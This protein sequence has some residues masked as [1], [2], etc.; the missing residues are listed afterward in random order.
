MFLIF[1]EKPSFLGEFGVFKHINNLS[2]LN[3]GTPRHPRP[4]MQNTQP[5]TR[6]EQIPVNQE[7]GIPQPDEEI[8][9]LKKI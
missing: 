3:A 8:L 7:R 5:V 6:Q 1:Q 9:L 4:I 2:G